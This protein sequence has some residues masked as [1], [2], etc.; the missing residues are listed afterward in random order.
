MIRQPTVPDANT[1]KDFLT[2]A[3]VVWLRAHDKPVPSKDD[4][5]DHISNHP[6]TQEKDMPT[7]EEENVSNDGA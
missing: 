1:E 3:L 6:V 7:L 5:N 2:N 4:L